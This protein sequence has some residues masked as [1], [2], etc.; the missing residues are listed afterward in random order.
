MWSS[1]GEGSDA[2]LGTQKEGAC[3]ASAGSPALGFDLPVLKVKSSPHNNHYAQAVA[4][5]PELGPATWGAGWGGPRKNPISFSFSLGIP[6]RTKSPPFKV[7]NS[8]RGLY[9]C[10]FFLRGGD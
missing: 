3:Q 5:D 10:L 8:Q 1:H 6:V 4:L 2:E 7:H 9:T